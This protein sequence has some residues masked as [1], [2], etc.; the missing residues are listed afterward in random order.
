MAV[1]V[2]DVPEQLQGA[3]LPASILEHEILGARLHGYSPEWLDTLAAAGEIRWVG[4]EPL[5]Q[6]DGRVA[7]YLS[8]Q[9]AALLPDPSGDP[10]TEREQKILDWLSRRPDEV[11]GREM[12]DVLGRDVWT[13]YHAYAEAAIEGER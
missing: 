9:M 8:D 11:L 6:R 13:L 12:A 3:A 7:L 1:K 2:F 4:V 5:G 10:P